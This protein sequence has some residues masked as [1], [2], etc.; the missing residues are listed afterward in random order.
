M[1]T[2]V[3]SSGAGTGDAAD[4]VNTTRPTGTQAGDHLFLVF[5]VAAAE[6]TPQTITGWTKLSGFNQ[7]ASPKFVIYDRIADLTA[8]DQPTI[9]PA[10]AWYGGWAMVAIRGGATISVAVALTTAAAV[11]SMTG[12]VV[13]TVAANSLILSIGM[14]G[15]SFVVSAPTGGPTDRHRANANYYGVGVA[16]QDMAAA[17]AGSAPTWAVGGTV[18][19]IVYALALTA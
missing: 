12:P 15:N 19:A 10:V 4:S 7:V 1:P 2:Y 5:H 18:N 11:T 13:T 6:T 9:N 14:I 16:T 3:A 8:T 17:G